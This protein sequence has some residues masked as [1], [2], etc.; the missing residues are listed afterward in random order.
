MLKSVSYNE[1][2]K[3]VLEGVVSF[4]Q[5]FQQQMK[6]K[7]DNYLFKNGTFAYLTKD[8]IKNT[9]CHPKYQ[10]DTPIFQMGYG[11][12]DIEPKYLRL[13]LDPFF[14]TFFVNRRDMPDIDI[15]IISSDFRFKYLEDFDTINFHKSIP[16]PK[17]TFFKRPSYL[18][19]V[20]TV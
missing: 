11:R 8:Q 15:D 13:V 1:N 2:F 5:S 12:I 17:S 18:D 6:Q 20:R 9:Y 7:I 4:P 10:S 14:Q 19:F 3:T 16:Q